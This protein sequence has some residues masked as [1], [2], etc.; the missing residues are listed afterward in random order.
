MLIFGFGQWDIVFVVC[1]EKREEKE[2][3]I[4]AG[5]VLFN[6][7]IKRLEENI[8]AI[9]NQVESIVII[10]NGSENKAEVEHLADKLR[11]QNVKIKLEYNT[12]NEGIAKA[13][14]QILQ[15]A[16]ANSYEWFLTLDQDSICSERLIEMYEPYIKD[17]VGQLSCIITDRNVG[18]ID[19]VDDFSNQ[20]VTEIPHCITS[21]CLNNTQAILT[22]GGYN[23]NLF[24]D[25]VDLEISY[26]LIKHGYKILCIAYNGLL[27]ELGNGVIKDFVGKRFALAY[28]V[29]WR[30]YY[31]RRNMIYVARKYNHGFTKTK[32]ILKQVVYGIGTI[33]LE[34]K[35]KDRFIQNFKG[36]IDGLKM[37]L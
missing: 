5:V 29:P 17:N 20:K 3:N 12:K 35:K 14:N 10:D 16:N 37:P 25:G 28:H 15:F 7:D 33:L 18:V 27:H 36:I 23:N 11:Q 31:T 26:N 4:C 13:L 21:G 9:K 32:M 30:N 19:R 24:I 8:S 22:C 34:D 1:A 6:P 2:M